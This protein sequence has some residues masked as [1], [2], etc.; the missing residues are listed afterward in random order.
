MKEMKGLM[1][2]IFMFK[3]I[4]KIITSDITNKLKSK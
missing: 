3:F 1:I 2:F 4:K